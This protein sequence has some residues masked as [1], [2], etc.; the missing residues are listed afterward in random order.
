[1]SCCSNNLAQ[2][3][4]CL[5]LWYQSENKFLPLYTR[6]VA[7]LGLW[8]NKSNLQTLTLGVTLVLPQL[9]T[10]W[11]NNPEVHTKRARWLTCTAIGSS[12]HKHNAEG[13]KHCCKHCCKVTHLVLS[14][15]VGSRSTL[16]LDSGK[17]N[18]KALPPS[19]CACTSSQVYEVSHMGIFELA[20]L[21]FS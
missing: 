19:S 15:V 17:T 6:W 7:I 13:C 8:I 1:M 9:S 14:Q 20:Q 5:D 11:D 3:L 21:V 4:P 16:D 12:W 18:S 2:L 10:E